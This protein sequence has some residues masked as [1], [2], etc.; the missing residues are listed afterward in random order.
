VQSGDAPYA[1][2]PT[3]AICIMFVALFGVACGKKTFSLRNPRVAPGELTRILSWPCRASCHAS[4]LV[5][6][7][8]DRAGW[9]SRGSRLGRSILV[10]AEYHEP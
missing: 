3:P 7:P 2:V 5:D 4:D 9:L 6:L 10:L 8:D 1:Y